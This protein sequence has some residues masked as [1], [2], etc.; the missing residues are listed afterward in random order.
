MK[1]VISQLRKIIREEVQRTL[2]KEAKFDVGDI[3]EEKGTDSGWWEILE[4]IPDNRTGKTVAKLKMF[5]P[6]GGRSPITHVIT[7]KLGKVRESVSHPGS[8]PLKDGGVVNRDSGEILD[9][10]VVPSQYLDH[11]EIDAKGYTTLSNDKFEKLRGELKRLSI[12]KPKKQWKAPFTF[13]LNKLNNESRDFNDYI[14]DVD[15]D[16]PTSWD[17][18]DPQDVHDEFLMLK[19]E[20]GEVP[21]KMLAA[22][23]G[24]ESNKIDWNGTGLRVINDVV[25]E[26]IGDT[27][28]KE[29]MGEAKGSK[30]PQ[31][32]KPKLGDIYRNKAGHQIS[33]EFLEGGDA[34][35]E[36]LARGKPKSLYGTAEELQAALIDGGFEFDRNEMT[37]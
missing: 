22:G 32:R 6:A 19:D 2:T 24:V 35:W 15:R 12:G 23:L 14:R 28:Y 29:K 16:M 27:P 37:Y 11:V 25:T 5:Q 36:L 3:V 17:S 7:D 18:P 1:I 21:L 30:V 20:K 9:M 13:R 31:T 8:L 10:T 34:G 4:L 33:V 26:L